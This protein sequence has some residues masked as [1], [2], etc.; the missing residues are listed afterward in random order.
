MDFEVHPDMKIQDSVSVHL[1]CL[2]RAEVEQTMRDLDPTASPET[3]MDALWKVKTEWPSKGKVVMEL[4][5][6]DIVGRSWLPRDFVGHRSH[7]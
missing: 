1:L 2:P 3:V 7:P 4:N 5:P 6:G